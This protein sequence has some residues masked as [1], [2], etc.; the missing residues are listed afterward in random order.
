MKMS[1]CCVWVLVEEM[2]VY[3]SVF[4][5]DSLC[6]GVKGGGVV[7]IFLG[8]KVLMDYCVLEDLLCKVF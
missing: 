5:V 4:V 6:G 3:F 1:Y 7:L 8:Y 2:N